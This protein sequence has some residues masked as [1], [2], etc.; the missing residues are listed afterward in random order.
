M[1]DL[2][3]KAEVFATKRWLDEATALLAAGWPGP[4]AVYG[5]IALE[6]DLKAKCLAGRIRTRRRAV[7]CLAI[8]LIRRDLISEEELRTV[9]VWGRVG[10]RAAH[11]HKVSS[12]QVS[13]MLSDVRKFIESH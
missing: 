8:S 10:S 4:A 12:P 13:E 9:F 5:R 7:Q 3:M 2:P 6:M 1:E 11:G